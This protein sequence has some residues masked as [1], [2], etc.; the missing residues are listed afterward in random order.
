MTL[1]RTLIR[2]VAGRAGTQARCY[3]WVHNRR[4]HGK[5]IF[6]DLRDRSG[7]LQ[8]VFRPNQPSLAAAQNL[9]AEWVIAVEGKIQERP[10]GSENLELDSGSVE[11]VAD[12][13][14]VISESQT[15]PFDITLAEEKIHDISEELRLKYRYL[16]MRRPA[17][18]TRLGMRAHALAYIREFLGSR[19]FMEVETPILTRSTPEGARDFLVPSR[20]HHGKFYALPQSPQQYKQ[21]LMVAGIERYFQIAKCFRDEDTRGD[22]QPE[23][24]QLDME[25]S[26]TSQEEILGISEELFVELTKKLVPQM[27]ISQVPFPRLTYKEAM[28]QYRSDRPDLRKDKNNRNELAF[29]WVVDFPMFEW[30]ETEKRWDAVH[31]PFT[32]PQLDDPEEVRKDPKNV[33]AWQYDLVLNG[34]EIGGGSLRTH[35]PVMLETTFEIMGNAKSDIQEKFGHLFEAFSYGVPPHG[36]IAPGLDRFLMVLCGQPNIREVI[37]FPKTGDG[38]DPTMRTP[39]SVTDSQ[40]KELG[41]ML[42]DEKYRGRRKGSKATGVLLTGKREGSPVKETSDER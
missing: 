14:E 39:A 38:R 3:G 30:K 2:D 26:F 28:E 7:I 33:L 21:L 23:F 19:D 41:L 11:L 10:N 5:L 8:V 35:D 27:Q 13:L 25:L 32:R 12:T 40:L 37:A 24:T 15:P 29:L 9:R 31:H 17:F 20:Q 16:D 4:D 1:T 34:I 22:R 6:V 42:R 18:R 36:G